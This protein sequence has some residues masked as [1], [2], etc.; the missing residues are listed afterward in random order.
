MPRVPNSTNTNRR[1]DLPPVNHDGPAPR[2]APGRP[3]WRF[4]ATNAVPAPTSERWSPV[5]DHPAHRARRSDR[6][7]RPDRTDLLRGRARM[8]RPDT[9]RGHPVSAVL[10]GPRSARATRPEHHAVMAAVMVLIA[11]D[12]GAREEDHRQDED[13][14][15]DD[16]HPR[17]RGVGG[18]AV[19]TCVGGVARSGVSLMSCILP[20]DGAAA[21]DSGD[22]S[23][24]EI[25]GARS[26]P[27]IGES[28]V[29]RRCVERRLLR[30]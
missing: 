22:K 10:P 11:E 26:R 28:P 18:G 30:V 5:P 17:R 12:H 3:G 4:N 15:R 16:N 8:G 29:A 20:L 1:Q 6:R 14:P 13:N 24:C 9:S 19:S 23:C 7:G 21:M 27:D 25:D 2:W